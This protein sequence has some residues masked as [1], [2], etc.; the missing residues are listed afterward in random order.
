MQAEASL[1]SSL[2]SNAPIAAAVIATVIL[3]LKRQREQ[4]DEF[5]ATLGQIIDTQSKRDQAMTEQVGRIA[6][7][8]TRLSDQ[9]DDHDRWERSVKGPFNQAS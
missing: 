4:G 9:L 1:V 6:T 8:L 5:R 3:F 2:V 7:E